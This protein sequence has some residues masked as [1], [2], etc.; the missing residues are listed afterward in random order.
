MGTLVERSPGTYRFKVYAG[1]DPVSGKKRW[2]YRTFKGGERAARK[3]LSAFEVEVG[4]ALV[5]G[6]DATLDRLL[7]DWL[8]TVATDRSPTTYADYVSKMDTHVRPALGHVRIRDLTP[9]HLETLYRSLQRP[10]GTLSRSTVE[11]IHSNIRRALNVARRWEWIDRNVA[12]LV[13]IPA[14][15]EPPEII[16]APPSWAVGAVIQT[17]AETDADMAVLL[18]VGAVSGMRRGELIGLHWSRLDLDLGL[19]DVARA[20]VK[21]NGSAP[22]EKTTK[23]RGRRILALDPTT[24]A[25]LRAHR[26]EIE[27]RARVCGVDLVADGYVFSRRADGSEPFRPASVSQKWKRTASKIE[28]AENVRLHDLRHWSASMINDA[29]HNQTTIKERLGHAS[30]TTT[31]RYM[32]GIAATDVAAAASIGSAL[33]AELGT[34][35][36]PVEVED[37]ATATDGVSFG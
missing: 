10:T 15:Q 14:E 29:G 25:L 2:Q 23:S 34:G 31:D 35:S 22:I 3:A 18:I 12:T 17:I 6:T 7:D 11:R 16:P 5:A 28:G 19:V 8:A 36:D 32:H 37:R 4:S 9:A 24:V 1:T 30:I 21:V 27:Q 13:E 33:F 20:V 26:V